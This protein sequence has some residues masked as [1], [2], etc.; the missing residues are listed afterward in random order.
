MGLT[1]QDMLDMGLG[2]VE[3]PEIIESPSSAVTKQDMLDMGFGT[4]N[5]E[6]P[7]TDEDKAQMNPSM[8]RVIEEEEAS[9]IH[10]PAVTESKGFFDEVGE[11]L[12]GF[13]QDVSKHVPDE[14]VNIDPITK[15]PIEEGTFPKDAK[16]LASE[17]LG[18]DPVSDKKGLP[19]FGTRWNISRASS[20][21]DKKTELLKGFPDFDVEI[22]NIEGS[23]ELVWKEPGTT[24]WNFV[25]EDD[26][27][28]DDAAEFL[29]EAPEMALEAAL[30]V[31][32]KGANLKTR[33]AFEGGG[34]A[35]I[36]AA[37]Q[38]VS[39]LRGAETRTQADRNKDVALAGFIPL[40]F[41]LG[42]R[43]GSKIIN[44]AQGAR[45]T[46]SPEAAAVRDIAE[47]YDLAG[48]TPGQAME[49]LNREEGK[50]AGL[51]NVIATAK[52]KQQIDLAKVW[53][54]QEKKLANWDSMD[55]LNLS[56]TV[57]KMEDELLERF[58]L[59][60]LKTN[61]RDGGKALKQGVS[62]WHTA[63]KLTSGR[64]Y[65]DAYDAL[66]EAAPAMF[67]M[68]LK[69][70]T[71]DT[72]FV[73]LGIQDTA[74]SI[75]K[76]SAP[77]LPKSIKA[78]SETD[79]ATL[80]MI[81]MHGTEADV[82]NFKKE[83]SKRNKVKFDD[84]IS[85]PIRS[86]A[87]KF[88]TIERH[89][90]GKGETK[91][92]LQIRSQLFDLK[93]KTPGAASLDQ[94]QKAA[95]EMYDSITR[96]LQQPTGG[97]KQFATKWQTAN[98]HYANF[99]NMAERP[100][101]NMVRQ[102]GE[103]LPDLVGQFVEHT[104]VVKLDDL[105]QILTPATRKTFRAAYQTELLN[106]PGAIAGKMDKFRND[107]GSFTQLIPTMDQEAF[108][109]YGLSW[110]QL[111]HHP[112]I[113]K[114]MSRS[115]TGVGRAKDLAT[116]A[117]IAELKQVIKIGG[118]PIKA[119]LRGGVINDIISPAMMKSK[120]NG[121]NATEI[122]ALTDKGLPIPPGGVDA[123]DP[124]VLADKITEYENSGLLDLIFDKEGI[125]FVKDMG[126]YSRY[127]KSVSDMG[128]SLQSA[129]VSARAFDAKA[130]LTHPLQWSGAVLELASAKT[131]AK[132]WT[133]P[134]FFNVIFGKKGKR[135]GQ[136]TINNFGA[137]AAMTGAMT[138]RMFEVEDDIQAQRAR[139]KSS[140]SPEQQEIY[141]QITGET[142][143]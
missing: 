137:A 46:L 118:E 83:W 139:I 16:R 49:V 132:I 19:S 10:E 133:H 32:T 17:Q 102:A 140:M 22:V 109:Q 108:R 123:L 36:E 27:T 101:I 79:N 84:S 78:I 35:A 65:G 88:K 48:L 138:N 80:Q 119:S 7:F 14:L 28:L 104:D 62:D 77:K 120:G 94:S 112:A 13:A 127:I 15:T 130:A 66:D 99:A 64:L 25:D 8:R 136:E 73:E 76:R 21:E 91:G 57:A 2:V 58:S 12:L 6:D 107:K 11:S 51:T 31:A 95:K 67:N 90:S 142:D 39:E 3:N 42:I 72:G 55:N 24:M 38:G 56:T 75:L 87:N 131:Q 96:T 129:G 111:Q 71:T 124:K 47:K 26:I 128:A 5:D 53:L 81:K 92:L 82:A 100:S 41:D 70:R 86:I 97:T 4:V 126:T 44:F 34:A 113:N 134:A 50:L 117:N 43:A 141:K 1:K 115:G 89:W 69:P 143:E 23:S 29:A 52:E 37:S 20:I 122:K 33:L 63:S 18:G 59:G 98:N 105:W 60:K 68:N 103:N 9:I 54:G 40:G 85:A 74:R 116:S 61:L 45:G 93:Q 135:I 125:E 30:F 106:N 121:L 110:N 114:L